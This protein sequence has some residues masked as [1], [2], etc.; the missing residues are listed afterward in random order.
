MKSVENKIRQKVWRMRKG[1]IFFSEDFLSLGTQASVNKALGQLAKKEVIIRLA[2][3]IYC[4]PEKDEVFGLGIMYPGIDKIAQAIA[5]RD[6]STIVPTGAYAQNRLGLSTQIPMNAVYLTNG[7]A[8]RIKI[9]N[10]KGIL[11]KRVSQKFFQFKSMMAMM[12]TLA[13]KDIGEG[14]VS[15]EQ[16]TILK[17]IVKNEPR[18]SMIQDYILMPD[19]IRTLVESLYD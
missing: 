10:G 19:W 7:T 1:S 4:K 2:H 5:S 3:G 16:K 6:K 15:D 13:L 14:N 18:Q 12:I 8:R 9:Y 17:K 11:F